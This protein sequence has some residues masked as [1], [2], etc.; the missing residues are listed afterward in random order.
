MRRPQGIP[1]GWPYVYTPYYFTA[2]NATMTRKEF[3]RYAWMVPAAPFLLQACANGQSQMAPTGDDPVTPDSLVVHAPPA[4][5]DTFEQPESAW[6]DE[7]SAEAYHILRE[8]G[9]E[10]PYASPLLNEKREGTFIC[11]GCNLPL[12]SSHT[13][14]E[15]GTGWPSYWAPLA[16]VLGTKRDT[17]LA[18]PRTEYHCAR[19][20]G[21]QGH[22]FKDGP[23]P[24]GLRYCNNGAALRFVPADEDLP[25]LRT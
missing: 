8:E 19:C 10:R 15:S 18:T 21:H 14:Y 1:R 25:P 13:M 7:L 5:F 17:K 3:F 11:K 12:F 9:T 6:R 24:T 22:V 20:E 23:D 4:S 2:L 16:G